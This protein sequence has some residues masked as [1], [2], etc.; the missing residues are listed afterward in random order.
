MRTMASGRGM[1]VAVVVPTFNEADNVEELL[2]RLSGA[3]AHLTATIVIV[4][5]GDD[6]LPQRVARMQPQSPLTVCVLRRGEPVG[7]LGGAVLEGVRRTSSD[8]VVVCDGDLQ[9]PPEL[10]GAMV[11]QLVDSDVVVASRYMGGGSA[12]GL[13][14]MLRHVISRGSVALSK[15]VFPRRLGDCSDPMSGFF[16]FRRDAVSIELL[17]PR[18][19][20]ILLEIIARSGPL[21]V[22]ELPFVFGERVFGVSHA[23]ASEGLRFLRQLLALRSA[24]YW[25]ALRPK[26]VAPLPEVRSGQ[27]PRQIR[28]AEPELF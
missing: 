3:L 28:S 7:R 26:P 15:T 18:G 11:E 14:G 6:D 16:A 24:A 22:V 13:S 5:D 20:K 10:I 8:V 9:H 4:D 23:T 12:Q 25:G 27:E 21:R 17:R 19:Y 2:G 1:S